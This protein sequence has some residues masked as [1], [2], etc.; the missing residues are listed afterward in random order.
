MATVFPKNFLWGVATSAYQIEGAAAEDGRGE[1]IWDRFA[2]TPGKIKDGATGD[3][4]CDHYH[5]YQ[6]DVRLIRALGANAYR[7]SISWPRVLPAGKGQMNQAGLDFY[8]R[9][10]DALLAAQI[11]PMVV[12]YHWDLPQA[13][14]ERGGWGN[15]DTAKIFAEYADRLARRLGDRVRLWTTHNE[16]WCT[17][18][19]GYYTG[20]FAPGRRDFALALQAAHHVLLSHGLAVPVLR[21]SARKDAQIGICPNLTVTYP[22]TERA[23]DIEAAQRHEAFFNAWFLD[24]LAGRGYPQALWEYYGDAVPQLEPDDLAQI[25]APLDFL[26][27]N[28]YNPNQIRH[29]PTG[30]M[31]QTR[32]VP[33]SRLQRTAD[34]EIYPAGLYELLTRL[35]REYPFPAYIV[36]ENG[37]AFPD[38]VAEDGTVSDPARIDFLDAHFAQ[39][40]RA[41]AAGVPL[42][43]YFVWSL[44]DNFEWSEGYTLRYGLTYVDF[45]TQQRIMKASGHWYR[46]FIEQN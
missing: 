5:R 2:H 31:P 15:R 7:F 13:L 22:A 23:E 17:A 16:M 28:Y 14:E 26:G 25:A 29:D 36:T 45:P 40:A 27:I 9:L 32:S 33:D 20:L 42:K 19:L 21:D 43:G 34:R 12:L 11:E 39:A 38:T 46:Q 6:E 41:I 1:S 8:S 4:A 10:V 24:P 30:P 18:F 35:R 37:A 3:A 44:M